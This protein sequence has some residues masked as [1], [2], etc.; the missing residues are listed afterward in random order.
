M[1][2]IGKIV[3][4]ALLL[5]GLAVPAAAQ[6]SQLDVEAGPNYAQVSLMGQ[7]N[8]FVIPLLS[9]GDVDAG[10]I[11]LGQGCVGN[12]YA[13]ADVS[14]SLSAAEDILRVYFTAQNVGE[15][16]TLVVRAPDGRFLCNDDFDG[17][18]PMVEITGPAEGEYLIWVGTFGSTA[19]YPGYLVATTGESRPGALSSTLLG[20]GGTGAGNA[21][22]PN[23]TADPLALLA[24]TLTA[25]AAAVNAAGAT[26]DPMAMIAPTLTAAMATVNAISASVAATP[27]PLPMQNA[28]VPGMLNLAAGFSP[29]PASL[30][31]AL[32]AGSTD[33]RQL[34]GGDCRGTINPLPA[35]LLTYTGGGTMLRIFFTSS[36]DTTIIVQRP[37]GQFVC[38][39][40][41]PGTL[42]PLV[43]IS[44]PAAGV[45]SVWLGTYNPGVTT[46]GTLYVSG[47]EASDPTTVNSGK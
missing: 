45:Y 27:T 25:A 43:D 42:N 31:L 16:T 5:T 10:S 37:D 35:V 9:G 22:L 47:S 13:S 3:V 36:E 8:L 29:D 30:P 4:L 18:N 14:V 38:G 17:S 24:P 39:D 40:D 2:G 26:Q 33:A 12:I 11:N 32:G 23:P 20:A 34:F 6:S 1:K 28:N 21:N 46:Q 7:T 44:A 41:S 15:D 19:N